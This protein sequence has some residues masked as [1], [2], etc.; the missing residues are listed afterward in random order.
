MSKS[1]VERGFLFL[2]LAEAISYYHYVKEGVPLMTKRS[3]KQN[4]SNQQGE[5]NES[6]NEEGIGL[7]L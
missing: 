2:A 4:S 1:K 6:D 5:D 7:A 3:A